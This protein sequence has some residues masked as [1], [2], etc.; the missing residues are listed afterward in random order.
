MFRMD[1]NRFHLI[2]AKAIRSPP[3][4]SS[5]SL[6]PNNHAHASSKRHLPADTQHD[7]TKDSLCCAKVASLKLP[8]VMLTQHNRIGSQMQHYCRDWIKSHSQCHRPA[9]KSR[10]IVR[11]NNMNE[12]SSYTM[13]TTWALKRAVIF[14]Q[15]AHVVFLWSRCSFESDGMMKCCLHRIKSPVCLIMSTISYVVF[16]Q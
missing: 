15:D 13:M 7:R 10:R 12:H 3:P 8:T 4:S 14:S 9:K 2:P 16:V 5:L 1:A 6:L 11:K